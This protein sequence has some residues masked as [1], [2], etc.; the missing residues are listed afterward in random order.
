MEDCGDSL[1][2]PFQLVAN[3][4]FIVVP[5]FANGSGLWVPKFGTLAFRGKVSSLIG[6]LN[7][8]LGCAQLPK[9]Q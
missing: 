8:V 2:V 1:D 6:D 9:K 5:R 3:P 7:V 4:A